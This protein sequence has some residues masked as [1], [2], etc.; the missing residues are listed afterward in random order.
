MK[1]SSLVFWILS[2]ILPFVFY[3]PGLATEP[4]KN[5]QA[6]TTL[7]VFDKLLSSKGIDPHHANFPLEAKRRIIKASE[8][9]KHAIIAGFLYRDLDKNNQFDPGEELSATLLGKPEIQGN[10]ISAETY[11]NCFWFHP[12]SPGNSYRVIYE[13]DGVDPVNIQIK[14]T[15]GLNILHVQITPV[16]PLVYI[17]PHSHFDVEWE[18]TYEQYLNLE[19]PH[20]Q[21]RLDILHQD[22]AHCFYNDEECVTRPFIERSEPKYIDMLR[23]GII[24]GMIEPKGII[25]QNELTMPYGESLIRNIT[26]GERMLSDMLGI[27]VRPV[28]FASIDQYGYGTQIPQILI[29][30]GRKY[31]L[32]GEYLGIDKE[33]NRIPHT[34]PEVRKHS[35]FWLKGLD[36]SKVLAYSD[37][38]YHFPT[39]VFP[40]LLDFGPGRTPV[41]SHKSALNLQGADNIAPV[42]ELT[43]YLD[44]LNAANGSNKYILS[45][46]PSLFRAIEND[47]DIPTF[48]SESFVTYWSGVYESRVEGRIRN[49]RIENKILATESLATIAGLKGMSYPQSTLN[50]AWY[51]LL[52]N[53]HHDPMLSVMAAQGLYEGSVLPRY[54]TAEAY[55]DAALEGTLNWLA[56]EITANDQPGTPVIVFNPFPGRRSFVVQAGIPSVQSAV[57]ITDLY[58]KP[59]TSQII[60]KSTQKTGVAFL[61]SDLPPLGWRTYYITKSSDPNTGSSRGVITSENLLENE[62]LRIEIS[63][64]IIQKIIDKDAG[65]IVFEAETSAGINEVLIWKDEGCISMVEPIDENEV[66]DFIDNPNAELLGRSSGP[67]NRQLTILE[68]GPSRG[69]LQIKYSLEWGMFVQRVSLEEGSRVIKF[70][71]DIQWNPGEKISDFNGRRVRVAFNSTVENAEVFCDI[72]FGVIE[73]EQSETIR[74]VVSWLGIGNKSGGAAFCHQGP[75]SIQVV[76]DV[77]YMTL[78]RSVVEPPREEAKCG[79]DHPADEATES[80][81]FSFNYSVYVY[82]DD[83]KNAQVP[84]VAAS[85]NVPVYVKMPYGNKGLLDGESSFM[86]IE[87]GDLVVSAVKPTEYSNSGIIVRLY[88]PTGES[89]RGTIDPGFPHGAVQ[90]VNFREELIKTLSEKYDHYI[91]DVAPY[92]IKTLR[93]L[94]GITK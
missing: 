5:H 90:E 88:N 21:Q 71:V 94:T 55:A 61:A 63:D 60:S 85:E 58:G 19:I 66:A 82:Q 73:W 2:L 39:K 78:L 34:I 64:G 84:Y 81:D 1:H 48:T 35:E 12:V 7:E 56:T 30:A 38:Y 23:Q 51:M 79:W 37:P 70:S 86:S 25:T 40:W 44:T 52:L 26:F 57:H 69:I 9:G 92:E 72:P 53:Q 91:L 46:T 75:Q 42:K 87:P 62:H 3:I 49:R 65:K 93:I 50:D 16:K 17:I 11:F 8:Q 18:K 67:I 27:K 45:P 29:K 15:A 80:G 54:E 77:V 10:K 83:W 33:S 41:L 47:P 22:P 89:V 43:S 20:I 24:D 6:D 31:F 4:G 59:V 76:N 36:G 28:V 32:L 68:T 74:P 13:H 14:P